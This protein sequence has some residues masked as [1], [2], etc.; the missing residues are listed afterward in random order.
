MELVFG[1]TN[2]NASQNSTL[3]REQK[4]AAFPKNP[5]KSGSKCLG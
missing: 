2:K 1:K 3:C 5:R 4:R